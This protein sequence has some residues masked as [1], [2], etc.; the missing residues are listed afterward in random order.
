MASGAREWARVRWGGVGAG[1]CWGV[2]QKQEGPPRQCRAGQ[3]RREALMLLVDAVG[4]FSTLGLE[5]LDVVSGFFH[6]AGHE[7]ADGM[8]LP[9]HLAHDLR[10]RGT[11]LPLEHSHYLGCLAALPRPGAF[12][13][14]RGL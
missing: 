3:E 10:Q 2:R 7:P 5:G 8:L 1:R 9:A 14:F 6:R 11:V 12:L 13:R 4:P